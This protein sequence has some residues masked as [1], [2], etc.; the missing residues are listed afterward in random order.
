M[1]SIQQCR[2]QR[3]CG[4]HRGSVFGTVRVAV[5]TANGTSAERDVRITTWSP[6][7]YTFDQSGKGQGIITFV[8]SASLAAPGRLGPRF[9]PR[10]SRRRPHYLPQWLRSGKPLDPQRSQFLRSG[11]HLR[12][13]PDPGREYQLRRTCTPVRWPVPDQLYGSSRTASGSSVP[14]VIRIGLLTSAANV[15]LA[16]L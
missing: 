1:W 16:L 15:T 2:W 10:Q 3:A 6:A 4:L 7:I 9:P 8:N 13:R 12:R 5:V 14:L 11:Q